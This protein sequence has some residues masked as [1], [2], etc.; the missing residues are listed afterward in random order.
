MEAQ[1]LEQIDVNEESTFLYLLFL[2][3]K[4]RCCCISLTCGYARFERI[5]GARNH[6]PT[7]ISRSIIQF[8]TLWKVL[9]LPCLTRYDQNS[10]LCVQSTDTSYYSPQHVEVSQTGFQGQP[11]D[12]YDHLKFHKLHETLPTDKSHYLMAILGEIHAGEPV[13][14]HYPGPTAAYVIE[15][16]DVL[17]VHINILLNVNATLHRWSLFG[18]WS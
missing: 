1:D 16:K 17:E 2:T 15:G 11:H 13:P 3:Q 14:A 12:D 9:S 18:W 4:V 7:N 8:F 10:L 6:G 5:K